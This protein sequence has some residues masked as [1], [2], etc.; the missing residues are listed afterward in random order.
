MLSGP[1]PV[2]LHLVATPIGNLEDVTFRAVRVL[3]EVHLI[4]AEDTR[5]TGKLLNHYGITTPR[6]S[7]HKHNEHEKTPRLLARLARGESIALVSDAGT[8][9]VSD[10]GAHLVRTALERGLG[11]QAVPGPSAVLTALVTSGFL[12]NSFAF[13]GFPPN[14]SKA[15]KAWFASLHDE[16][17]PLVFF[18]APHRIRRSLQD[19]LEVLGDR[20]VALCRELTKLHEELVVGPISA[21]LRQLSHPRGEITVVLQ[22]VEA[23]SGNPGGLPKGTKLFAEFC[24]LTERGA[25][26]RVAINV[27]AQQYGIPARQ[28]YREIEVEK[29]KMSS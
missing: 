26:R 19:M 4:A 12:E 7:F 9:L 11:V 10:P 27:L 16:P 22:P 17:R 5:R 20:T 14:R 3:R 28:V 23:H 29:Q 1:K 18:E 2:T 6:T 8:P 21:I 15:R 13:V 25:T 24:R